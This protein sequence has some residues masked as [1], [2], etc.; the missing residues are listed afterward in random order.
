[1]PE[2]KLGAGSQVL[3]KASAIQ[4]GGQEHPSTAS[5]SQEV[6][7]SVKKLLQRIRTAHEAG[8][9]KEVNHLARLYL[10]SFEARRIAVTEA[11]SHLSERRRPS[12]DRCHRYA[13]GLNAWAGTTEKVIVRAQEKPGKPGHYRT[14]MDFG[15]ENR[16][17]QLH[18]LRLLRVLANPRPSQ[19]MMRGGV[20]A[21]IT[22]A[23]QALQGGHIWAMETDLTNCYPSFNE[24]VVPE[25]LPI[26]KEVTRR[27]L[28]A[29]SLSL[30]LS[31]DQFGPATSVDDDQIIIGEL[32]ADARQGIPQ[33]S[34]ASPLVAELLLAPSFD[35]LPQEGASIGYADNFLAMGKNESEAVA[36]TLAFW[37]ALKASP[38]GHFLPKKPTIF[39][40]G[41]PIDFLGHCLE[42]SGA[43]VR[44]TPSLYNLSNFKAKLKARLS[45][46][47]NAESSV[48]QKMHSRAA[49]DF[50]LSWTAAFKLCDGIDIHRLEALKK[51]K[52]SQA[53]SKLIRAA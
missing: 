3:G 48:A 11:C 33:G 22:R 1:M 24:E 17:L 23:S 52:A 41:T 19:F 44:I 16:S 10:K 6:T 14:I 29:V 46:I 43:E 36:M 49:R 4:V 9:P 47:R 45:S 15:I 39:E 34:S 32:F 53:K 42:K 8:K 51:I 20:H 40:P 35:N 26:P 7:G 21:A 13:E 37:S 18:V 50:V 12:A 2:L 30:W 5:K 38:A 28:L 25:L 27:V 31:T